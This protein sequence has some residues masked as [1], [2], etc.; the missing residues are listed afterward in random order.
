MSEAILGERK[1]QLLIDI[2]HAKAAVNRTQSKRS[3]P[4]VDAW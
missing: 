3:A 2:W 4:F 1:S